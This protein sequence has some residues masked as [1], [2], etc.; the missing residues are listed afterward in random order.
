MIKA[1]HDKI[2]VSILKLEKTSGGLFIAPNA[3][4]PQL[5][6]KVLSVGETVKN[7]SVGNVIVCN[8][9]A[10][11]DMLINTKLL[12]CLKYDEVYGILTD[13]GVINQLGE[14]VVTQQ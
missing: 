11:M 12:K 9:R 3:K 1:V 4:D 14:T 6:G 8:P 7:I 5:Y 13:E 2:I 10:G